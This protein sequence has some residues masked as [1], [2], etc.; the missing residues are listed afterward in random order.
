MD[1]DFKGKR[2]SERLTMCQT[3]CELES[4]VL[5]SLEFDTAI[6]GIV[7]LCV[8]GQESPGDLRDRA[9]W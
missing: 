3:P 4:I 8:R 9:Q 5:L 1:L 7:T 2:S 6:I